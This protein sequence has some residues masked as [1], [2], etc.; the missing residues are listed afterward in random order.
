[1]KAWK[2]AQEKVIILQN[3]RHSEREALKQLHDKT[4]PL[5]FEFSTANGAGGG[6]ETEVFCL[7]PRQD[8]DTGICSDTRRLCVASVALL[9]LGC[10]SRSE[11]VA[12]LLRPSFVSCC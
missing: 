3:A 2:E 8:A 12:S 11:E 6:L 7:S 1:M 10:D 4:Q 5:N 9:G